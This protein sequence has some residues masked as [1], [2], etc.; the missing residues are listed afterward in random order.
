MHKTILKIE[1]V[2]KDLDFPG[3]AREKDSG[4]DVRS[5][6]DYI[7]VPGESKLIKIGIKIELPDGFEAQLRPRS[8]IAYKSVVTVLNSPGTI[9]KHFLD[10]IGV[11]LINHGNNEFRIK[12]NDRIAQMVI[13]PV[14]Y[15]DLVEVEEV[16]GDDRGGGF[17]HSGIE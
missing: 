14:A 15:C 4:F 11:I 12:R 5:T 7:L 3:Y 16:G 9:D 13:A 6:I 8:G 1:K 17:G 2:D 10:E